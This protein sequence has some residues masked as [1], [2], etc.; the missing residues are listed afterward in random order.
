MRPPQQT[1]PRGP[2]RLRWRL[3]ATAI[4]LTLGSA[5]AAAPRA[6]MRLPFRDAGLTAE[7][8]AAYLLD[9][10]AYGARPGE[11]ARVA[12]MG[13]EVWLTHQLAGD[14][15][16]LRLERELAPLQSLGMTTAETFA[17]YPPRA[18]VLR[19]ARA[20]GVVAGRSSAA[21]D[22]D[23]DAGDLDRDALR[24]AL[25]RYA[26]RRGYRSPR[27]AIGELVSAKVWRAVDAENQ[28]R[29]VLADFWF[30]HFNVSL[31]KNRARP[32]VAGF[33]R[34]AIR[35]HVLGSFRELLGATAKH[36]AMLLYLD[37]AA[38][39]AAADASTTVTAAPRHGGMFGRRDAGGPSRLFGSRGRGGLDADDR[40][41]RFAGRPAAKERPRGVNENYARE[42]MELHTLGV[43]GGYQQQDVVDVAR[44]LTGWTVVPPRAVRP[45]AEARIA[46]ALRAGV[47]FEVEG[48]FLFRA[49]AHDAGP[50]RVLGH[51]L[52]AG[53]GIE[54]G[55]EVLDI[56]AAHPSTARLVARK[57]AV[58]F[59]SD[60][61]PPALVERLA[62]TFLATHGDLAALVRALAESPEFWA[63]AG[64]RGK[65]K[66]PF[67]LAASALR[68]LGAEVDD[69]LDTAR[70]IARMGQQPYAYQ[71]PTGWPDR[72][73][74]WVNSG[75]LLNRMSFGLE[76]AA[77]RIDGV[78]VD[79]ARLSAGAEPASQS[80]ALARFMPLLL[81]QRPSAETVR[82]LGPILG[83]PELARRLAEAKASAPGDPLAAE[84][85]EIAGED[86]RSMRRRTGD[87]AGR[88]FGWSGR[89]DPDRP[90]A[91]RTFAPPTPLEEVVGVIL[92][93]PEFQRR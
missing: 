93:S 58:R 40:S 25:R 82:E 88:G 90:T 16:E 45:D 32:F 41:Q 19:E 37:N 14:L 18:L 31:T 30:N 35:P 33:E 77:G 50:K 26:S 21:G 2:R 8:A 6:T 13:P 79:L 78:R 84:F 46:R 73:A 89:R 60:T 12:A 62:Q 4:L 69:P 20:A 70:W 65:I 75:A 34:D 10:F 80:E 51:A 42:L 74:Q 76:L 56:L 81:P 71:A 11:V 53:R 86:R 27:E 63:E 92:G 5:A 15:P 48:D 3:G 47:G 24:A 17:A 66:S 44:A 54:D 57:L 87:D 68:A 28:L 83:S 52:P 38:S 22:E 29:E 36:P 91:A 7:Q 43:D 61:P 55:E 39:T 72:A 9:R 49:D 64:H 85:D 23:E 67:E 1:L 59:V